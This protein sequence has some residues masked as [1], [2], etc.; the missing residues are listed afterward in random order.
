MLNTYGECGFEGRD[1]KGH[2]NDWR[3]W[4]GTPE[5]YEGLLTDNYYAILAVPARQT[6][7]PWTAGFRP[8]IR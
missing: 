3:R 4:D 8:R 5:G 6:K 1:A 2:S 7:V